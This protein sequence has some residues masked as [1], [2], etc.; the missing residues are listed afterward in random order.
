[1]EAG[2]EGLNTSDRYQR[3]R[4]LLHFAG[5]NRAGVNCLANLATRFGLTIAM[6]V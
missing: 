3:N 1:M 5:R 6:R 4:I 2:N